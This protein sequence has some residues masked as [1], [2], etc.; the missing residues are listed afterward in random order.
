MSMSK[1]TNPQDLTHSRLPCSLHKSRMGTISLTGG[2]S[3]QG[4]SRPPAIS[5]RR[6]SAVNFSQ[7]CARQS[8]VSTQ[9]TAEP[10][11]AALWVVSSAAS[12]FLTL[13][14]STWTP[15]GA[16]PLDPALILLFLWCCVSQ[17]LVNFT[18]RESSGKRGPQLRER[19]HQI[20][21]G[22]V[23]GHFLY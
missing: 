1:Y 12:C 13:R 5:S 4:R 21:C 10:Q 7:I 15:L 9:S 11:Q 14:H 22:E 20:A 18:Q 16:L 3:S 2:S 6:V 23:W 17:S 19:L 8:T